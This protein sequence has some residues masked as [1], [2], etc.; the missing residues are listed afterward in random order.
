MQTLKTAWS[1]VSKMDKNS[2]FKE[3]VTEK[4]A[5]GY[6]KIIK[7]PMD[8]GTILKKVFYAGA[9]FVIL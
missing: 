9:C 6:H 8:L 1:S 7:T 4:I 2:W 5:E 3:P